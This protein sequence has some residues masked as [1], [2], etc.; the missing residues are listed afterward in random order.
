L[1]DKKAKLGGYNM[2][3]I[4]I[5]KDF[6]DSP[7]G[8]YI[9]EGPYSGEYFRDNLLIPKYLKAKD[10]N[11]KILIDLDG[12]YGYAT[13]FLDEAFGGIAELYNKDDVLNRIEFKSK[14]QPGLVEVI[15]EYIKKR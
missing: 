12:T 14:D 3:E 2:F 9:N 4:K 15:I 7:G 1:E 6:S 10:V 11:E 8:R 5:S 13:S